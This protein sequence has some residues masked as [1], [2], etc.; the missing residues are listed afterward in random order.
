[1]SP[2][3][4]VAKVPDHVINDGDEEIEDDAQML[5]IV[6]ARRLVLGTGAGRHGS[7]TG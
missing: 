2:K 5:E 4:A 3:G 1:M 6:F 7:R